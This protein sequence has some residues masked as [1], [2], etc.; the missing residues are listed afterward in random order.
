MTTTSD[1]EQLR[2]AVQD[3]YAAVA[4]GT[5]CCHGEEAGPC[6]GSSVTFAFG[7]D[8]TAGKLY[9][10]EA[11]TAVPDAAA[12]AS[13]GCGN[14]VALGDLKPG[15]TVI[16]L[17]SGGGIDCFLAA[18]AVGPE[19]RVIGIDMTHAMVELARAN[20]KKVGADNVVF[21]LAPIEAIPVPDSS[22]DMVISNCVIALAPDKDAV[23]NEAFRVLRPG[24][25]M[26]V[27]DRVTVGEIPDEVSADPEE[28][29]AC[30]AGAEDRDV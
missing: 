16:D 8:V 2:K 12:A 9:S 17:G 25:R 28:W 11:L 5:D 1:P 30:V 29:V 24:G 15:E 20:A 19:G 6:C 26:F 23:F 4:T 13:A 21:K 3:H 10:S 18:R 14:P 27:S 7:D 22:A